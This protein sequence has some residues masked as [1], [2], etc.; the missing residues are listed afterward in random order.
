MSIRLQKS[1]WKLYVKYLCYIKATEFSF[2][3]LFFSL[4]YSKIIALIN[5]LFIG[6]FVQ[7]GLEKLV[8]LDLMNVRILTNAFIILIYV[9]KEE[10]VE[11]Y[12][13]KRILSF[14]YFLFLMNMYDNETF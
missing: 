2:H 13:V 1:H 6:V 10:S 3:V 12:K 14:C 11:M 5:H 8:Q 9:V 4:L 7:V